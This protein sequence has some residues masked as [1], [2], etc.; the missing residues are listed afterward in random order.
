[1]A[2][3]YPSSRC[4]A[5]PA[6]ALLPAAIPAHPPRTVSDGCLACCSWH[7]I[8][9]APHLGERGVLGMLVPPDALKLHRAG[10]APLAGRLGAHCQAPLQAQAT[11]KGPGWAL[12]PVSVPW[13]EEWWG[14]RRLAGGGGAIAVPLLQAHASHAVAC[15]ACCACH[16]L[17]EGSVGTP[18]A[19]LGAPGHAPRPRCPQQTPPRP[20]RRPLGQATRRRP[21]RRRLWWRGRDPACSPCGPWAGGGWP[22]WRPVG[23]GRLAVRPAGIAG[24]TTGPAGPGGESW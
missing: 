11:Q 6:S 18:A 8:P 2:Q 16:D 13:E 21:W 3:L 20:A 22:G 19:T 4:S 7:P 24:R 14:Q 5:L 10:P 12:V 23:P 9:R 15:P 1:V 17:P